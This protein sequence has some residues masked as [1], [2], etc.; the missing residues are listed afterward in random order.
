MIP[1]KKGRQKGDPIPNSVCHD[2]TEYNSETL[3]YQARH[4]AA[5]FGMLPDTASTVAT[6]AFYGVLRA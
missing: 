1:T 3:S 2:S 4:L 6:L 5:T